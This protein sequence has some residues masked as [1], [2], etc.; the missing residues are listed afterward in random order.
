MLDVVR[1]GSFATGGRTAST[2]IIACLGYLRIS[3]YGY[4]T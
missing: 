3:K 1:Q 4:V 2:L